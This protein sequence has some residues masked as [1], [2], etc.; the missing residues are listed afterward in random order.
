MFFSNRQDVLEAVRSVINALPQAV[1]LVS[2]EGVIEMANAGA[3]RFGL[4]ARQEIKAL[5]MKWLPALVAEAIA[6]G[7]AAGP[8][9]RGMG[10]AHR[11]APV[12]VVEEGRELHFLPQAQPVV[13]GA[14]RLVGIAVVLIEVTDEKRV[15]EVRQG[16]LSNLSHKLKSPMT[17][18][19]MSIHLLLEDAVDC[20]T[21][22]QM[23]LLK[24]AGE[25]AD[26]LYRQI[27]ELL[28]MARQKR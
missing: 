24:A 16:I 28:T 8:A 12:Q 18:I 14:G 6:K 9:V 25:D 5:P 21:P 3:E 27:E 7:A 19:Q 11:D 26:R 10:E 13:D 2:P 1:A 22:R 17:S 20:L 4:V 15:E 23:E